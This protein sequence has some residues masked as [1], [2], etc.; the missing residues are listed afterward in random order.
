MGGAIS[1]TKLADN[2]VTA[3]MENFEFDI[4]VR[5]TK[6][7]LVVVK[8]R[9]DPQSYFCTG[10]TFN[11]QARAALS[12]LPYRSVVYIDN[13]VAQMPDGRTPTLNTMVFTIQ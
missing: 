2:E 8:P 9:Q 13:V 5:V 6:F 1:G 3:V 7:T 10:D 12:N 11:A 4:K